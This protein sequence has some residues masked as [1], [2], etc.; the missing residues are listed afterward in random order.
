MLSS[1]RHGLRCK[2]R[3]G[4]EQAREGAAASKVPACSRRRAAHTGWHR[5]CARQTETPVIKEHPLV[6]ET[7]RE[8]LPDRVGRAGLSDADRKPHGAGCGSRRANTARSSAACRSASLRESQPVRG[9]SF[10]KG[11]G[12][13][14]AQP[15]RSGHPRPAPPAPSMPFAAQPSSAGRPCC[16][17]TLCLTASKQLEDGAL[18][19]AQFGRALASPQLPHDRAGTPSK[20]GQGSPMLSSASRGPRF[21]RRHGVR[22]RRG[23]QGGAARRDRSSRAAREI[24]PPRTW[25]GPVL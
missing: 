11:A 8:P 18:P 9:A 16:S 1:S 24:C 7:G 13:T 20:V 15:P 4:H 2:V 12:V 17:V 23:V 19:S 25:E 6:K 5:P 21:L 3:G 14:P 10:V 22:V